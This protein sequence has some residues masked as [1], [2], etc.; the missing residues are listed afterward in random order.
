MS[1]IGLVEKY[2]KFYMPNLMD[3]DKSL[4]DVKDLVGKKEES[5]ETPGKM[6][7]DPREWWRETYDAPSTKPPR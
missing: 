5:T 7:K 3:S 2:K 6:K 4:P 1:I